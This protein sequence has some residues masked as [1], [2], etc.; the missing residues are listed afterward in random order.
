MKPVD[1]LVVAT[2]IKTITTRLQY[3]KVLGSIPCQT[4]T[5]SMEQSSS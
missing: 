2:G 5:T 3:S 4:A 1:M